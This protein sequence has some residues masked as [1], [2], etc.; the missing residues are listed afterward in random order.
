MFHVYSLYFLVST[1]L[2][3]LWL[4]LIKRTELIFINTCCWPRCY[5]T[6][7]RK[8]VKSV[9]SEPQSEVTLLKC[10]PW[11]SRLEWKSLLSL[12]RCLSSHIN[13]CHCSRW[14]VWWEISTTDTHRR[15]SESAKSHQRVRRRLMKEPFITAKLSRTTG[16]TK[17]PKT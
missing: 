9:W 11:G 4:R 5:T 2:I 6:S 8:D 10:L 13:A 16:S 14:V 15:R 12:L 3:R 17:V 1:F 7:A